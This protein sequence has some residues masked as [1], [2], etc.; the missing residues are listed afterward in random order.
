MPRRR[1][2]VQVS[3]RPPQRR[4]P[5]PPALTLPILDPTPTHEPFAHRST[6]CSIF[7]RRR[8]T[9]SLDRSLSYVGA[10][11]GESVERD[12]RSASHARSSPTS[13][14]P[15][16]TPGERSGDSA[17]D[18]FAV[19]SPPQV[20]LLQ[21]PSPSAHLHHLLLPLLLLDS[22][23]CLECSMRSLELLLV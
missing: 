15:S 14:V 4:S 1:R 20:P 3:N 23:R 13:V 8:R 7:C 19:V 17:G 22:I 11:W 5:A 18:A 9:S 16:R 6:S 21:I 10:G 12:R 2:R